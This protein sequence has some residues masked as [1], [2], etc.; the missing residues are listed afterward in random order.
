MEDVPPYVS[1][2]NGENHTLVEA[3]EQELNR[4]ADLERGVA[5]HGLEVLE[6][7]DH[8]VERSR[9]EDRSAWWSHAP[10][11]TRALPFV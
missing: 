9:D 10:S 5:A 6:V 7:H 11:C 4:G 2:L 3:L 8:I 1:C